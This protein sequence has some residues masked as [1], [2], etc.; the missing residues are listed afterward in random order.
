MR[1]AK[2][3]FQDYDRLHKAIL[4][5]GNAEGTCNEYSFHL[6]RIEEFF[7]KSISEVSD[8]EMREFLFLAITDEELKPQTTNLYRAAYIFYKEMV[9]FQTVDKR[10]LPRRTADDRI[11]LILTRDEIEVFLNHFELRD[12]CILSLC[13][14]SGARISE[15]LGISFSDIH[16]G[17][18][19]SLT[20]RHGKGGKD[21]VTMLSESS[22]R[23]LEE[24]YRQF[25]PSLGTASTLFF[26][27]DNDPF[28]PMSPSGIQRTFRKVADTLY[29]DR[30]QSLT[31]HTLRHCFATHLL[32]DGVDL[33]TLQLL[34]GHSSYR[35]TC[36]YTHMTTQHF[37]K[38]RSPLDQ[39]YA[40]E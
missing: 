15:A 36:V 18:V 16:R 9:L 11:P 28:K 37:S 33:R 8:S 32:D 4:L 22:L 2:P 6:R 23:Y 25:H 21:R 20:I 14:G 34:L 26:P 35:S 10:I 7:G 27:D 31:T 40:N 38:L 30:S 3:R 39:V 12:K 5:S 29:P 19:L 1:S 13:Y 17:N 24:Y